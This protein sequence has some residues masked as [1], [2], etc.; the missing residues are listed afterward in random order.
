[1]KLPNINKRQIMQ[2]LADGKRLDEREAFEQ[3]EIS[4]E[5]EISNKAEGT[6]RVRIGKTE[7]IVG[8]KI[9][10]QE[11]YTD[12]SDEGTMTIGMEFNPICGERYE[13]GPPGMDSIEVARVVDRGIRES[14]FIDWKKLCIKEGEVVWALSIDIYCINDDGNV[15]DASALGAVA[16]LKSSRLPVYNEEEGR[17]EFGELTDT[18]IP[19]TENV[20]LAMTF[21]KI[22]ENLLVDPNRDEED[23]SDGRLTLAIS[24]PEKDKIINSM[25]KGGA[26]AFTG[27]ELNRIVEEAEKIYEKLFPELDKKI[28]EL[29][30]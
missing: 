7:V 21:Y 27:D 22:G 20:P 25:Q 30:K 18:P 13:H 1:M 23:S 5:T 6:A 28:Q 15:L 4:I 10:T 8:V 3:R 2:L 29:K 19:L 14:G 11:P 16:A 17:V 12:H 9:N 26:V 24:S